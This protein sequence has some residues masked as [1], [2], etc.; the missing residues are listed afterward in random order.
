MLF[1]GINKV[2]NGRIIMKDGSRDVLQRKINR[3]RQYANQC[4]IT[5]DLEEYREA[6]KEIANLEEEFK[7]LM[8]N[9]QIKDA[10]AVAL[11]QIR[12]LKRSM[13]RDTA[14]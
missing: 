8:K 5:G 11:D 6:L 10:A 7:N 14:S 13:A 12:K 9:L 4:R 1:K 3:L 2:G